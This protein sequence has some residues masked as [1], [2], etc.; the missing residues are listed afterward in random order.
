MLVLCSICVLTFICFSYT[1]YNHF[2]NWDDD[3]YVT[4][5]P[6]IKEFTPHN[7]KVIFTED[8]TKNN[9][10][11]LC[12]LSLAINYHFSQLDPRG[13]YLT[14]IG[15]HIANVVLVF[16][17]LLALCRRLKLD[18]TSC[19]FI[20]SFAALWFGVHPMRVESVSWI[21]ERKDVLYAFFYFAA[22]LAYLRYISSHK[23]TWY[24]ATFLLFAASCLSKPMAVVLPLSL[25][26]VDF[27][28]NRPLNKKLLAEKILF[29]AGSLACGGAAIYT[30]H[31][32][33]AIASFSTLT[34]AQRLMYP[35]YSFVMY[36]S[37]L[38]N[39]TYLSTFYPYPIYYNTGYLPA[40]FYLAPF[41]ALAILI[42]PVYLCYTKF[43]AYL[44]VVGFGI[45]YFFVNV[46]F[47]LQFLSVGAAIMSDRYTYVAYF[48]LFFLVAYL[49]NALRKRVPSLQVAIIILLLACSGG[50]AYGCY[51]R[52]FVWHDAESLL[53]DAIDKYPIKKDPDKPHDSN[54]TGIAGLSYKWRG[55]L[56]LDSSRYDS[57]LAD[58]SVYVLLQRDDA[59]VY[60]K[61]GLVYAYKKDYKKA[62]ETFSQALALKNTF[63]NAYVHRSMAYVMMGDT[64]NAL[65][66]FIVAYQIA[67]AKAE[68]TLAEGSYSEIQKQLNVPAL[69]QYNML[70]KINTG[71]PFYYFYRGVAYFQLGYMEPAIADWE[72]ALKFNVAATNM[73]A[74]N[75]LSVA[76]DN[77]GKDSLAYYYVQMAVATGNS[78]KPDFVESLKQKAKAQSKK[79]K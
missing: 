11:P 8:I 42:I 34:F 41:M 20:T 37:K 33:G 15:I 56:D 75:N 31:H 26:C 74:S 72:M 7:L 23:W 36:V 16:F 21:A 50:L 54:N 12:M 29:F 19:L 70:L 32:T 24:I 2:T 58:Y 59:A 69:L 76:Y 57:A 47:I 64:L 10:H 9:Y 14:N 39:P 44:R 28:L 18:E 60:D 17:L 22:M 30:Q 79:A 3:F 77:I 25:L 5:D 73:S 62:M 4:N 53:S 40:I 6:Y 55:N 45:G 13:Y 63:Y 67:G 78:V 52:T 68:Q 49:L 43:K 51:Q 46:V 65:R 27:L 48:S 35:S 71:N 66:D 38:F 61:L 1:Q